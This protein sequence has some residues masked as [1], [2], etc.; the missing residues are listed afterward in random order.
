MQIYVI[1]E[2]LKLPVGVKM[3]HVHMKEY[4]YIYGFDQSL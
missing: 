2:P 3:Y 1:Q 4:F